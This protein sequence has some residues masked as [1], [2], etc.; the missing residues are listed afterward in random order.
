MI[1][2]FG[3]E[4]GLRETKRT[5]KVSA[6]KTFCVLLLMHITRVCLASDIVDTDYYR[7]FINADAT[8]TFINKNTG[9]T[10][11]SNS[12]Q[13]YYSY[14]A[15]T[16]TSKPLTNSSFEIDDNNDNIP[17][18]WSVDK[19]YIRLSTEHASDGI[20][21]LKFDATSADT[22]YRHAFSP[23]ITITPDAKY[24]ISIDSYMSSCT[25]GNGI[26]VYAY[27][28]E[29]ANATGT[30]RDSPTCIIVPTNI[31]SWAHTSFEWV[32]PTSARSFKI[33]IF[34][35]TSSIMTVYFDNIS[36]TETVNVYATDQNSINHNLV[37][38]PKPVPNSSFEIDDNNDKIPDSWPVDKS[39][40]RL[41]TEQASDG[42]KSLKFDANAPDTSYRHAY[43][44]LITI[45]PGAQYTINFDSYMSSFTSGYAQ[46]Y[47]YYYTTA[48]GTGTG[49]SAN[50]SNVPNSTGSWKHNSFAWTPPASAL[51]FKVMIYMDK[52]S[53][54]TVYF[55]NVSIAETIDVPTY[56]GSVVDHNLTVNG[57]TTTI[58][59]TDNNNPYVTV[60]H[61]YLL[62]AH[63][64]YINYTVNLQ[65][66]QDVCTTGERFDFTVPSQN[67]QV[68]TRDLR[69]NPLNIGQIYWSDIYT[70]KVVR[71]ANGL[72]F[73]GSDTMESMQLQTSGSNSQ[74]SFYSDYEWDH[75]HIPYIKYG[76]GASRYINETQRAA[77]D[78]YSASV[79]FAIDT[80]ESLPYLVKTRQPYG[81]DAV[82]TFTNHPDNETVPRIKAV[83]YGTEDANDPNYGTKGIAGRGLGW[84]KG[85]FVFKNGSTVSL[86][87]SNF[88]T[89]T[90]QMYQDGVEIVGHSIT[91]D[92]DSRGVVA[93][94]LQTLSQYN[95]R[96]WID[97]SA[98]GGK[99]NW[100]DLSSQGAIKGNS[101]YILDLLDEYNYQYA[102]SY[103][104]VTTDSYAINMLRPY[105]T[106]D[107]RPF[108]FYNNRVDD[109]IYDNKKIYLWSTMNTSKIPDLFYTYRHVDNLISE[110]GVH[111][112]H[113]YVGYSTCKNHTWYTDYNDNNTIKIYPPFDSE[114]E[115][116]AQKRA[117]GLLWSPTMV[118]LG[119]YLVS[120]KD[121]LIT[122][123]SNGKVTVTNNSTEDVTG[124]TLLAEN[125][126]QSVTIGDYNLVSF[127][128]SYGDNEIVLPT[129]AAGDPVV[130]NIS[131]GTKDTSIPTIASND[132]GINKVNEIT[133]Y[134]DDPNKTLIMT[135]E[136][137]DDN[138]SFTVTMPSEFNKTFTVRD[139]T[140]NT[141]IGDYNSSGNGVITFTA[142]LGSFI[143]TFKIMKKPVIIEIVD[144]FDTYASNS[145][146]ETV[147]NPGYLTHVELNTDPN[148]VHDG[149]Q[150]MLYSY[151]GDSE[152]EVNTEN[153]PCQIKS[154]WLL[155]DLRGL[156]MY[157]YGDPSNS[158]LPMYVKLKD[159]SD[160][161]G[162]VTYGD[163]GE[164]LNDLRVSG[165][166][167]WHINLGDFNSAGVDLTN[168]SYMYLGFGEGTGSG[169]LYFDDVQLY[170]PG[171]CALSM[172]SADFTKFDFAPAGNPCGDCIID[173]Q[174]I[175]AMGNEWL[176]APPPDPNADLNNDGIIDFRD[177]AFLANMW[178][179]AQLQ[180]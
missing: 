10:I 27:Y 5:I 66:K 58:T 4:K 174:E 45:T 153:L 173:Y 143:H 55:D 12:P 21:S 170:Q 24:T 67:A 28:Y 160:N 165:W 175:K 102:W 161:E 80:N 119:D 29:T 118:D 6:R 103:L 136:A 71:F 99:S 95:A 168:V 15:T 152:V 112:G 180:P 138:Y 130:L 101:F 72:S 116:M 169:N 79:S 133:G 20:K 31:G 177:F 14:G 111:I 43:S 65:Y 88:K 150:S 158:V 8:L 16:S 164:D 134:W 149:N 38:T 126:V 93:S 91:E 23:L 163:H 59:A 57:D 19:T 39:Y 46:V 105:T 139:I 82:S 167:Q 121:A 108:L 142:S 11:L 13:F 156:R 178:L 125:N 2:C 90:D 32:P 47:T 69:L 115:Y 146:L 123:D 9:A 3:S 157:F 155:E 98:A 171:T 110:R 131:Y 159:G 76:N 37:T 162:T 25:A 107:L 35:N 51:S 77:G 33:M 60:N 7:A 148:F 41:S 92:T 113:E 85:V 117:D 141:N 50:Y 172:R 120:L 145:K 151:Q 94:G 74:I 179:Q 17:D 109:N 73:L 30:A 26:W 83:A 140:I 124:I 53:I 137:R 54:M 97:H 166:H 81:Y 1:F 44:P 176:M 52:L 22:S 132:T 96:N 36:I 114:L 154:N 84:T 62:N 49:V 63:S 104:D 106:S 42:L 70:P 34:M 128:G 89:L 61:Q 87:D 144:D 56:I 78:T 135:A 68:M 40:I 64:P 18:G 86:A 122:Y 129:I 127:G 100:E 48:N 75:P 147:W